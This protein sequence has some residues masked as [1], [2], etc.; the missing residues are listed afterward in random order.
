MALHCSSYARRVRSILREVV[1]LFPPVLRRRC[2]RLLFLP[3]IRDCYLFD[4]TPHTF[5][6]VLAT[7]MAVD[8]FLP[9]TTILTR[10]LPVFDVYIITSGA[11]SFVTPPAA[12][13][14]DGSL[15]EHA[16]DWV[17]D[18]DEEREE[19]LAAT[20]EP[21]DGKRA[22]EIGLAN[23]A[24][25]R[26][27]L[28]AKTIEFANKLEK[29]NPSVLRYTKEAV[30]AVRHMT[31]EEARDYLGAKQDSLAR[32]DKEIADKVGMK[33]FLDEKSYRPGLGPYQRPQEK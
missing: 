9:G 5:A 14:G 30:R 18:E 12:D 19:A 1:E 23:F 24:V 26:D 10:N 7:M 28:R 13:G 33:K 32:A 25:P 15:D 6:S 27:Q 21:F 17:G 8:L 2:K 16:E 29:L 31:A 22:V 11:V 4:R 3:L 20:G